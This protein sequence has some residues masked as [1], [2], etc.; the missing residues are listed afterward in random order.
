MHVDS[1]QGTKGRESKQDRCTVTWVTCKHA[2]VEGTAVHLTQQ[3][4]FVICIHTYFNYFKIN[5]PE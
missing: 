1:R 4:M 2:V 5:F 3:A